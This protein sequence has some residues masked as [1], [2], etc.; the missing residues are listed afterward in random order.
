[1]I[2]YLFL[3]LDGVMIVEDHSLDHKINILDFMI[4]KH[5]MKIVVSSSHR[6][7]DVEETKKYLLEKG[8][9][10]VITDN[11]V[12]ITI[13][14]YKY[15]DKTKK[16]HLSIP[17]GVEIKQWIDANIH[18]ENGKNYKRKI[19]GY[20]YNYV[21]I[22]DDS[23]FLLEQKDNFI[24]TDPSIGLVEAHNED[25][26]RILSKLPVKTQS[27]IEEPEY[28]VFKDLFIK[29]VGVDFNVWKENLKSI[30]PMSDEIILSDGIYEY[31]IDAYD[32]T[33]SLRKLIF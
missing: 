1:M 33:H 24:N 9:P 20:H 11:I 10:R 14:A 18:S 12:G 19:K 32:Q 29:E 13:R 16:I 4:H 22:D 15:L 28:G 27:L 30:S 6:K 25:L 26:D 5:Y 21:I 7:I 31:F 17:R 23:D 2:N 3:D 8:F